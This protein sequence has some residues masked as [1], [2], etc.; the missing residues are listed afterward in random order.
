MREEVL[1]LRSIYTWDSELTTLKDFNLTIFKG[2]VV[3]LTGI[4]GS[5]KKTVKDLLSGNIGYSGDIRMK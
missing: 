4:Y 1:S 3:Y 5:G 2:E